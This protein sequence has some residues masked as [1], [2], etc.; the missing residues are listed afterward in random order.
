MNGAKIGVSAGRACRDCELLIGVERG[1]FLKL[2]LDAH[3]GVRFVVLINPGHFLSRLHGQGGGIE[4]EI[5]DLYFVLLA[6][7]VLHFASESEE[8]QIEKSDAAQERRDFI[9]GS[10]C[11]HILNGFGLAEVRVDHG[12]GTFA[13]LVLNAR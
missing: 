10:N 2:L 13:L 12:E 4:R 5:F 8:G 6:A 1:R 3:H 11:R 9:F 7:G